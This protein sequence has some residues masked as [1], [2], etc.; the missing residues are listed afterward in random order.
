MFASQLFKNFKLLFLA[1][2]GTAAVLI[3]YAV[4]YFE[5]HR[6]PVITFFDV[7]QGDAIFIEMPNGNQ[8]LVDG[9]PSDVILSKLGRTLPFWDRS[10]NLLVLTH[11]HADHLD[12]M[13]EVLRRY[14]I[15]VVLG[16]GVNHSIPEYEEWRKLLKALGIKV[17]VARAGQRVRLSSEIYLDILTPLEDFEN[18]SLKNVHDAVVI[19]K[20]VNASST[21]LFMGDAE[22]SLEYQL[23]FSGID[24]DVDLLKVGHHGSKTSTS[25]EF[26]KQVSPELA[27]ISAGRKN[28]YGHPAQEVI[29]R[30]RS[31]GTTIFRTDEDRDIKFVSDGR[32]FYYLTGGSR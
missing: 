1:I 10:I 20:L 7:G 8:V 26:L 14:K 27:L 28:R 16:S 13:L 30:L 2:L 19:S 6:Y 31:F 22:K 32:H 29:D 12:G 3:W 4:F 15:D 21:I 17:V 18:K 24:V 25:E 11:P 23:L 9:G 5:S